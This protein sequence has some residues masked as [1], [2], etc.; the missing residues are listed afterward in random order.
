MLPVGELKRGTALILDNEPYVVTAFEFVKPGKG[1]AM[2]R[3]KLRNLVTGAVIEKTFR[4][5]DSFE[6][7]HLDQREAQYLYREGDSYTFMDNQTYEQFAISEDIL[8]DAKN[9]LIDNLPVEIVFFRDKPIGVQ[10]PNFINLR[11]VKCEPWTKGDTSGSDSKPATLETGFVL[12]VPPFIN[13]GDL[14]QID[15]RTGEYLSRVK[16]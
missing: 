9:Y 12:R 7:A 6:P 15:T 3:T 16:E 2:Y 14:I 13:E 5:G 8:G 4:S 1:Q 11:V 10:V